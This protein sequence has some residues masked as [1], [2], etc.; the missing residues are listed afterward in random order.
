MSNMLETQFQWQPLTNSQIRPTKN[1][2]DFSDIDQVVDILEIGCSCAKLP[3]LKC[4][5]HVMKQK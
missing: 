2:T 1:Q 4:L 3:K 5:M